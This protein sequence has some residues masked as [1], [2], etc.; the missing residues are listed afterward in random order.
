MVAGGRLYAALLS[1]FMS[2]MAGFYQKT[3]VVKCVNHRAGVPVSKAS[4]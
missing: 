2:R 1:Y 4:P 3:G